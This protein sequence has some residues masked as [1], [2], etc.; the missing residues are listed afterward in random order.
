MAPSEFGF[1]GRRRTDLVGVVDVAEQVVQR[2]DQRHLL[3]GD[4]L[5]LVVL[6][7][8]LVEVRRLATLVERLVDLGVAVEDQVAG[9][10]GG[11]TRDGWRRAR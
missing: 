7:L 4:L 10:V 5:D 11:E 9:V 1:A 2:G 6:R 3:A 8:A